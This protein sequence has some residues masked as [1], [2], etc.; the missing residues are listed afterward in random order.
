MFAKR[1]GL[2][3]FSSLQAVKRALGTRKIGHT[4]TLDT[5]ADGLLVVLTDG[6]T[7]LVSH[8]TAFDKCY[9][10][11]FRFGCETD[12]L[13]PEGR[14]VAEA[15]LPDEQ[16]FREVLER[17]RGAILQQPPS[18]SAVRVAGRRASDIVRGGNA[19]ELP[20]RPVVIRSLSVSSFTGDSACLRVCCSKGTYVRSLARDIARACG[21][22]G[23][24]T[25]LRRLSVGPFRLEDAAGFSYLPP[26]GSSG[27]SGQEPSDGEIRG[28]LCPFTPSLAEKTGFIPVFL[29]SSFAGDF[30]NGRSP[31]ESWF[32]FPEKESSGVPAAGYA[33]FGE[34]G[35]NQPFCGVLY[36]GR[37]A[38]TFR[39]GFVS[40][41]ERE[42]I[43]LG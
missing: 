13:D 14:V 18:Y 29:K 2:T 26:F 8:I 28:A 7:K 27:P 37:E 33:V 39:Y 21:S 42:N 4:G 1:A 30:F 36:R 20:A 34:K 5:F 11:V 6:L 43:Q 17:F 9:E 19:V 31:Q 25:A 10:A 22:R 15:P 38:G 12:T 32:V 24:V 3:S 41:K 16:V 23:Y 35:E 40:G